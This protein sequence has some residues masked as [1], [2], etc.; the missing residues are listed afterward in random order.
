MATCV[1]S[2]V[3]V[4]LNALDYLLLENNILARVSTVIEV[5]KICTV[6]PTAIRLSEYIDLYYLKILLTVRLNS[7]AWK[8]YFSPYID[9]YY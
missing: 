4:I 8:I 3:D 5:A 7:A 2:A 9:L 6:V 1:A